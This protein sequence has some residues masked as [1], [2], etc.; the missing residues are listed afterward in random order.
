MNNNPIAYF[1]AF[2][3]EP[4]HKKNNNL[5]VRS[6]AVTAQLISAFVFST[7]NE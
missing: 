5:H 4:P 6:A 7:Q 1:H 2:T 3:F